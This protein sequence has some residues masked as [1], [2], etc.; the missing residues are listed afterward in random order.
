MASFRL[1]PTD[2]NAN[3]GCGTGCAMLFVIGGTACALLLIW[4][5]FGVG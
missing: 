5:W 1:T 3:I 2:P 4:A